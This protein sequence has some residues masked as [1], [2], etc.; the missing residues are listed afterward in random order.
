MKPAMRTLLPFVALLLAAGTAAVAEEADLGSVDFAN[1]GDLAA[2]D[3]FVRAILLLHSF[4]YEDAEE[5]FQVV[6]QFD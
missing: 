4:E 1:S 2:Q 5:A 6:S 3:E